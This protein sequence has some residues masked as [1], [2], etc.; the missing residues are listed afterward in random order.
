MKI[1]LNNKNIKLIEKVTTDV[2][3]KDEEIIGYNEKEE[4]YISIKGN[5]VIEQD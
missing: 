4:V 5:E 1:I 2:K 3:I